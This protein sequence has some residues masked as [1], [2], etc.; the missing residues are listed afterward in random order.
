MKIEWNKVTWYSK[1]LALALFVVLLFAGFWFGACYGASRQYV[2]DV[3][4]LAQRSSPS[5]MSF[6]ESIPS[7]YENV[8]EWQTDQNH[9]GWSIAYPI[10]F[11]TNDS[12]SAAPTQNWRQG[13]PGGSGAQLLALTIPK[14]FEPQT[15]FD[16]AVLTIGTSSDR[17]AVA[18][19]LVAEPSDGPSGDT[20]STAIINGIP[21]TVFHLTDVGA[22]NI[23]ETT[24]YRTIHAGQ[25]WAVEY[26]IHS[27]EI[28]NYPASYGLQ[29]FDAAKL[30]NVLDRIVG[31][32]KF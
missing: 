32:F 25:C 20:T 4:V 26:T 21:F 29:P 8:T 17:N 13:M 9:K 15:N 18:Q 3:L 23:Y 5:P 7:Y 14:V 31:T 12:Y 10:D 24:S 16:D 19:C 11:P 1:A 2:A 28:G 27:S 6:N 22:G 30:D